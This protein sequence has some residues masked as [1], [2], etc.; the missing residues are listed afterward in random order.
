[1]RQAKAQWKSNCQ[2]LKIH[3]GSTHLTSMGC[4]MD[5]VLQPEIDWAV[6]FEKRHHRVSLRMLQPLTR[7][8]LGGAK[9]RKSGIA[10][11]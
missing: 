7:V 5:V 10:L 11:L 6:G 3:K 2:A 8:V 4:E 1:M 9:L